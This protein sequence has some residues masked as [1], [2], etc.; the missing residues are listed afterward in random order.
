MPTQDNDAPTVCHDCIGDEFLAAEVRVQGAP[1]LC[2]YCSKTREAQPLEVLAARIH[3]VL[4][5]HFELTPGYPLEG[6]EYYLAREGRWE[7]RG[8]PVV[9]VVADMAGV[10]EEI[11]GDV[12]RLLYQEHDYPNYYQAVK[13]GGDIEMAYDSDAHYEEGRP[14]DGDFHSMWAEVRDE[15]GSRARFFN[16]AAEEMLGSIFADLDAH[17]ASSGQRV[18]REIG[19]GDED[20]FI[21][22]AREAQSIRQLRAI[23]EAPTREMGPPPPQLAKG[24]RMNAPG[25]PVFYGAMDKSTC[26]AE[27][28]APVGSQVVVA[29]FDLLRTLRLLDLDILAEVYVEGSCF[30]PEY[31]VRK[32]RAAFLRRLASEISRPVMPQDETVEYLAT[33]VVAEF[34]ANKSTPR[35]DGIIF[36]SSQTGGTGHNVVLFAHACGVTPYNPPPGTDVEISMPRAYEEDEDDDDRDI[37]VFENTTSAQPPEVPSR[38][39]HERRANSVHPSYEVSKGIEDEGEERAVPSSYREGTLQLDLDSMVVLDIEGVDYTYS[40][41]AVRRTRFIDGQVTGTTAF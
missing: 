10:R 33:Q 36:R 1:S 12:I 23:L 24:G 30:D 37:L 41:R 19:P 35:L 26:V 4:H 6:Y 17:K 7:R 22:R 3:E 29:K 21:W 40:D 14:D 39:K 15:I 8:Y 38:T 31:A 18:V 5:E 9:D 25:I 20:R 2:S 32:G 27:L 13:D 34:L 11:A 16:A 28:R